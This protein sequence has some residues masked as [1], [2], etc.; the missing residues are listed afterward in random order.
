MSAANADVAVLKQLPRH[1]RYVA[2]C[3]AV[4]PAFD[5]R[6]A[7]QRKVAVPQMASWACAAGA[8]SLRSRGAVSTL[9]PHVYA[10][11]QMRSLWSAAGCPPRPRRALQRAPSRQASTSPSG[12]ALQ[13]AFDVIHSTQ[14]AAMMPSLHG[15]DIVEVGTPMLMAS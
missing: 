10:P 6:P 11:L 12:I 5:L 3:A 7:H 2:C 14:A 1:R 8:A 15:V 4:P 13:V 9:P